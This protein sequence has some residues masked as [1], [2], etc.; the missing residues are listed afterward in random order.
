[1]PSL[2]YDPD[3]TRWKRI[4]FACVGIGLVC[5]AATIALG[6][7]HAPTPAAVQT[8]DRTGTSTWTSEFPPPYHKKLVRESK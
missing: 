4:A 5:M 7:S 1:M 2:R 8:D 3:L 6:C